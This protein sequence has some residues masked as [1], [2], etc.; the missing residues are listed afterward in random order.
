[1]RK[2]GFP[3]HRVAVIR[4]MQAANQA[5]KIDPAAT[6][7]TLR[8]TYAS[9]LVQA[10]TPLLYVASALGHRDARMVER[11]YGHFAPSQVA[12]TI[13]ANLPEFGITASRKVQRIGVRRNTA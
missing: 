5:A 6:F 1:M 8:H 12:A 13:R 4:A 2:E 10:G 3:W 11:H 9:Q 7:Y